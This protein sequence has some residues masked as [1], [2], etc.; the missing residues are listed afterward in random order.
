MTSLL[1]RVKKHN[2]REEQRRRVAYRLSSLDDSETAAIKHPLSEE[3]AKTYFR[4][5]SANQIAFF[6]LVKL[7]EVELNT[8]FPL[9]I[10]PELKWREDILRLGFSDSTLL[11]LACLMKADA[12]VSALLRAGADP[13]LVHISDS[14]RKYLMEMFPIRYS[15]WILLQISTMYVPLKE[16]LNA[17]N[18]CPLCPNS[19]SPTSELSPHP[20]SISSN[21]SIKDCI[22]RV[23]F[24]C[25]LQ[26]FCERCVWKWVCRK[27]T[28]HSFNCPGCSSKLDT[29]EESNGENDDILESF[30]ER[31]EHISESDLQTIKNRQLCSLRK[32]ISLPET[33]SSGANEGKRP[34][35][36]KG[37]FH[38][39]SM[40][41]ICQSYLGDTRVKR[42]AKLSCAAIEDLPLRILALSKAGMMVDDCAMDIKD[43]SLSPHNHSINSKLDTRSDKSEVEKVEADNVGGGREY[44]Q[45][46]LHLAVHY[47]NTAAVKALLWCGA[48]PN[49]VDNSRTT[50][51]IMAAALRKKSILDLLIK[52]KGDLSWRNIF[53]LN[54]VDIEANI[55]VPMQRIEQ[56]CKAIPVGNLAVSTV[57]KIEKINTS[58]GDAFIVDH[59]ISEGLIDKLIFLYHGLPTAPPCKSSR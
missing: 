2:K 1:I 37:N 43:A 50:P 11:Q 20:A 12:I 8:R 34:Y 56:S 58:S 40:R 19:S 46:A 47:G 59:A 16:D 36:R 31:E 3:E 48:N 27:Q 29:D 7:S 53:G 25:C 14:T 22:A 44:G 21:H 51:V 6:G 32:W 9:S 45:T 52:T 55:C 54:A 26:I 38:A 10:I 57:P 5:L 23:Q 24:P 28:L 17:G 30:L 42:S 41:E 18:G 13:C 49:C 39:M 4:A 33:C 35:R 15:V